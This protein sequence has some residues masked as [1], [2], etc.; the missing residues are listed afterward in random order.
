MSDELRGTEANGLM[1]D[2]QASTSIPEDYVPKMMT[3]EKGPESQQNTTVA[4]CTVEDL[5]KEADV[6]RKQGITINGQRF[7]GECEHPKDPEPNNKI[8]KDPEEMRRVL[9]E[10]SEKLPKREFAGENGNPIPET[11]KPVIVISE[12]P[13]PETPV[14]EEGNPLPILDPT[15]VNLKDLTTEE[16]M[17]LYKLSVDVKNNP[18]LNPVPHLPESIRKYIIED[19]KAMGF[20]PQ[21]I[22]FL[23][24]EMVLAFG[25]EIAMDKEIQDLQDEI[26]R[27][28]NIP[29]FMDF[30][31]EA[32]RDTYEIKLKEQAEQETDPDKKANMLLISKAFTDSYTLEPLMAMFEDQGFVGKIVKLLRKKANMLCDDFDY[33]LNKIIVKRVSVRSMVTDL[34]AIYPE[35][36]PWRRELLV[37]FLV[38]RCRFATKEDKYMMMYMYSSLFN[39]RS[40]ASAENTDLEKDNVEFSVK[41]RGY[42]DAFFEKTKEIFPDSEFPEQKNAKKK[43]KKA[44]R[45]SK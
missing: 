40:L 45:T 10:A 6:M 16:I 14:D 4:T 31:G 28:M 42:L 17:G 37:L 5:E 7:V 19:G 30:Y 8:H 27:A 21:Q 15:K 36:E 41:R 12:P 38:Y 44:R 32:L 20:S 9:K 1:V 25:N 35:M 24:R 43:G 29:E 26:T 18:K 13:A 39:T 11:A 34:K 2:E 22:I 23:A 3:A 33:V